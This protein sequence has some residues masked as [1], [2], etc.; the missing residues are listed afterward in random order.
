MAKIAGVQL[1]E[2]KLN[3][4]LAREISVIRIK[5]R[6]RDHVREASC[7]NQVCVKTQS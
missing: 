7:E 2:D 1:V 6:L 4:Q 5:A 3:K